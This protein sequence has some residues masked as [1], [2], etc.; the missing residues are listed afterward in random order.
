MRSP[1]RSL[2]DPFTKSATGSCSAWWCGGGIS[3]AAAR[4]RIRGDAVHRPGRGLPVDHGDMGPRAAAARPSPCRGMDARADREQGQG[5]EGTNGSRGLGKFRA[6]EFMHVCA[7]RKGSSRGSAL[8]ASARARRG[9]DCKVRS[10][11]PHGTFAGEV[12]TSEQVCS[13]AARGGA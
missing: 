10:D 1:G 13:A 12:Y 2:P 5:R 3:A 8:S 9:H 11:C 7:A 6:G 4:R